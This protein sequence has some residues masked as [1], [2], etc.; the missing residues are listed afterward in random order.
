M[1]LEIQ[2]GQ[3]GDIV[4]VT[5]A[6]VLDSSQVKSFRDQVLLSSADARAVLLDCTALSYLDSSGLSA[7][8]GLFKTFTV[9]E[10]KFV[11]FGLSESVMRVIRFTKLDSVLALADDRATALAMLD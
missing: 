8:V 4:C 6:G 7:F 1:S 2:V 3:E 11:L 9:D 5:V 10:K